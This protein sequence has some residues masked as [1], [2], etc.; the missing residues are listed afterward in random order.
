LKTGNCLAING[1]NTLTI[2]KSVDATD[3]WFAD[4]KMFVRLDDGREIAV[5]IDWFPRLRDAS[6]EQRN[7]WRFIGGGEGIHWEDIDEDILVEGLLH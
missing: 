4:T 6:D 2:N 1:M 3:V 7:K 5:P